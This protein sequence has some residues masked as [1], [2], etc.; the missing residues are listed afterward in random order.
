[1]NDD[2]RTEHPAPV[3]GPLYEG[4]NRALC[5]WLLC[6]LDRLAQRR[7]AIDAAVTAGLSELEVAGHRRS[8]ARDHL[9]LH[10]ELERGLV[11][12]GVRLAA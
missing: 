6:Q 1:M 2:L 10:D 12:R 4:D 8:L 11:A 3:A 9:R 5:D 7:E